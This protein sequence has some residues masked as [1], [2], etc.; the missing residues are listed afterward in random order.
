ML[1]ATTLPA[2][3]YLTQD[4][5]LKLAFPDST[6][7]EPFAGEPT[8]EQL[9]QVAKRAKSR[10]QGKGPRAWVARTRDRLDGVALIDH[11][12]GRT[13]YITFL[14]A[15][16]ASGRIRRLEVMAYRESQGGEVRNRRFLEQFT[17]KGSD[18]PL[19]RGREI[20]NI[21]GATLS[22]DALTER[23]RYL[24]DYHAV[25]LAPAISVAPAHP[26]A[27]APIQVSPQPGA[28]VTQRAAAIGNSAL[29]IRIDHDGSDSACRDAESC[30][31]A[32]LALAGERDAV[33]NA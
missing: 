1:F 8:A 12:I 29:T 22:V 20:T 19:R 13:E 3:D 18:D 4:E 26:P 23:T 28:R 16:D 15:L 9:D 7:I 11:V 27:V 5:A 14:C 32:A 10:A 24:L 2:V 31:D 21:G 17:G 33:L 25:V 6:L 30:A